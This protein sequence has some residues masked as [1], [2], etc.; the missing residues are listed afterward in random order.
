MNMASALQIRL[1]KLTLSFST[2]LNREIALQAFVFL[3]AFLGYMFTVAPTVFSLDSAEF[4]AAVYGLGVPHSTGYPLYILL[5]KVFTF[6]PFG[7]IAYRVNLMSSVFA[8]GTVWVLYNIARSISG[9]ALSSAATSLLLAFS[10]YFWAAAV[11][12]EVYSLH[13]FLLA[14][15]I[16]FLVRWDRGNGSKFLFWAAF[17]WGL[18]FGNHM[19]TV[20]IAPAFAYLVGVAWW[21]KR[22]TFREI[23]VSAVCFLPALSLYAYFPIRYLAADAWPFLAGSYGS[24][25]EF[26]RLDLTKFEG[27]W[28]LLT[29]RQF[30]N[31]LFAFTG[32]NLVVELG[33]ML[34]W[35]FASFLGV[36]IALGVFGMVR[37]WSSDRRLLIF[38]GIVFVAHTLFF[39]SYGAVDKD[40]MVLAV[41]LV[42]GIWLSQGLEYLMSLIE[43]HKS[44]PLTVLRNTAFSRGLGVL[45]WGSLVFVLPI[46]ALVVNFSYADVSD[47]T[48]IRDRYTNVLNEIDSNALVLG[49]WAQTAPMNYL[50]QVDGLRPDIKIIDRFL[51]SPENERL[52][53]ENSLARRPVYVFGQIPALTVNYE[54]ESVLE[55][56]LE[57]WRLSPSN[58]SP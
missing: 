8:A 44:P 3:A 45:G 34:W 12:A 51:I 41:Y 22:T 54:S 10:Y 58:S 18:S 56:L 48:Q 1:S 15:V 36:G 13:V 47:D 20:L 42:W 7:D 55:P 52:L 30:D 17:V 28:W 38:L 49:W 26:L 31:I 46:T 50:Q 29:D 2:A 24:D 37:S 14:G 19:T 23:A 4:S 16:Y 25:G 32:W 6:L 39:A 57:A 21:Q 35:L 11:V 5:G 40:R 53:L 43:N 27:I 9:R 33:Q